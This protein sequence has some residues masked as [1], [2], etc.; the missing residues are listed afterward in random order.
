M[1][2]IRCYRD[3]GKVYRISFREGLEGFLEEMGFELSFKGCE[4]IKLDVLCELGGWGAMVGEK[5]NL[6]R[7][8]F[9]NKDMGEFRYSVWMVG[10]RG[11]CVLLS[12]YFKARGREKGG[13]RSRIRFFVLGLGVCNAFYR[14]VELLGVLFMRVK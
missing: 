11:S 2:D 4:G 14:Y 10:I 7:G 8:N 9:V 1:I 6:K 13:W 5:D 12:I 3:I